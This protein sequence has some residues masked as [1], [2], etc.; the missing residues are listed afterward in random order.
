MMRT[1]DF[2][3][4]TANNKEDL[5]LGQLERWLMCLGCGHIYLKKH[6]FSLVF[7]DRLATDASMERKNISFLYFFLTDECLESF[8]KSCCLLVC[9]RKG[10][11]HDDTESEMNGS[12]LLYKFILSFSSLKFVSMFSVS[13]KILP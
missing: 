11:F 3:L 2:A 10:Y 1:G 6:V 12:F 9:M 4:K 13:N 7:E 8:R 5:I